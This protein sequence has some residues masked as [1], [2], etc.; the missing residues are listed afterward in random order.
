MEDIVKIDIYFDGACKNV[1]DSDKE[2]FGVG[3]A[4]FIE[5]EYSE[6]YSKHMWGAQGT[7]NI[8]E[9][10]GCVEAFEIAYFLHQIVSGVIG[11]PP[12]RIG[13][14]QITIYSDSE[15][16]TKQ[17][18]GQYQIKKEEF[19]WYFNEANR[20]AGKFEPGM[21]I[22]W[23]PREQ[24]TKADEL[25]KKG[26]NLMKNKAWWFHDE[27]DSLFIDSKNSTELLDQGNIQLGDAIKCNKEE[28]LEVLKENN[29]SEELIEKIESLYTI[30]YSLN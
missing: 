12:V 27:S 2:P 7:S 18:N 9:W 28:L 11:N 8:A 24:N 16:I 4:V 14:P 1:K 20:L 22:T 21:K 19:K 5:D 15:L 29:W 10:T 23:I 6:V 17:F 13:K 26:L 25:S 30:S 3:V